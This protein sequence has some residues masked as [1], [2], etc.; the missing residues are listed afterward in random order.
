VPLTRAFIT[1]GLLNATLASS[2]PPDTF[3][4]A[5]IKISAGAP[6]EG[7]RSSITHTPTSLTMRNVHLTDCIM[8]AYGVELYQISGEDALPNQHYD[9]LA[10]AASPTPVSQLRRMLQQLLAERFKLTLHRETKPLPVYELTIAK[11]GPK[12]PPANLDREDR[13]VVERLPHVEDGSFVF[14]DSTLPEFAAKLSL[15]RGMDRP[16]VDKTGISGFFNITLK[17]AAAALLQENGPSLFTLVPEQLGLKLVPAKA[18]IE[19]LVIDH[20]DNP[21]AN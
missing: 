19:I 10:K 6:G 12:L 20:A 3:E 11:G 15:L 21:T 14:P 8:W 1:V 9:I 16:V 17:T 7:R 18:P 4:V 13:H 5:S 2:Q